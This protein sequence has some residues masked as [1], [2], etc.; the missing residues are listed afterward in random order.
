M[1][2]LGVLIRSHL[3]SH[4]AT[5]VQFVLIPFL[6]VFT[7][8]WN[9]HKNRSWFDLCRRCKKITPT[10]LWSSRSQN[11]R[12][13]EPF[14]YSFMTRTSSALWEHAYSACLTRTNDGR[15]S[16]YMLTAVSHPRPGND[17]V[18]NPELFFKLLLTAE[19]QNGINCLRSPVTNALLK[20]VWFRLAISH[21]QR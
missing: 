5:H 18:I 1:K 9:N 6:A 12:N 19:G 17:C 14:S 8:G 13:A 16:A 7:D 2:G 4:E 3:L 20:I 15:P 10:I 11:K 21:C